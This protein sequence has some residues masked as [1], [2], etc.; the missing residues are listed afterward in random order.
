MTRNLHIVLFLSFTPPTDITL[1]NLLQSLAQIE[2]LFPSG[3]VSLEFGQITDIPDV[4]SLAI[5]G[6][7]DRIEFLSDD[8]LT[9]L[10]R[11]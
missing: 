9:E 11:L 5:L 10:N 4:I 8:F 7:I 2:L 1:I 6:G 3:I